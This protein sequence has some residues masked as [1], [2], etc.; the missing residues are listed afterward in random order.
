MKYIAQVIA[1]AGMMFLISGCS[2]PTQSNLGGMNGGVCNN[3]KCKC[4]KPCQCGAGCRCG[5]NGNP[6]N[7][8]GN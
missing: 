4:P 3:P 6:T 1:A 7:L 8:N 5:M 2:T